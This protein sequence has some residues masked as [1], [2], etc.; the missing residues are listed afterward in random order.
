LVDAVSE[1]LDIPATEIEPPPPF[2]TSIQREFILGMGK[3]KGRFVIIL[4]PAKA[5]DVD[6]MAAL[7]APGGSP[8]TAG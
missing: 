5:L 1:V 3:V 7:A 8:A 6:E 2:G 4:D